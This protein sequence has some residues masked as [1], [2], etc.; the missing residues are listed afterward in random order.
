MTV[1]MNMK[2]EEGEQ[3]FRAAF[4]LFILLLVLYV[5][6]EMRRRQRYIPVV[7]KPSNDSLILLK[8]SDVFITT[9]AITG[10]SVGR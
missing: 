5:L 1:L 9:A 3:P 10:I 2:N 4:W 8:P 6:M 7:R